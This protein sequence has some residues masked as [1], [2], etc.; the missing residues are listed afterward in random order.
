MMTHDFPRIRVDSLL[1][2][3]VHTI[4]SWYN[5]NFHSHYDLVAAIVKLGYARTVCGLRNT[6]F[7]GI[8]KTNTTVKFSIPR[9]ISGHFEYSAM[10]LS[11]EDGRHCAGPLPGDGLT[12]IHHSLHSNNGGDLPGTKRDADGSFF[13]VWGDKT[14]R[15]YAPANFHR[16]PFRKK[17]EI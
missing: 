17:G 3:A 9:R 10:F 7:R 5:S 8:N 15:S 6:C 13:K 16:A 11:P 4:F 1:Q 14:S 12:G 2:I